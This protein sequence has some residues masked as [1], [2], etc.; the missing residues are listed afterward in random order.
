MR[1][2]KA[3]LRFALATFMAFVG[4]LIASLAITENIPN[5]SRLI[6]VSL[7]AASFGVFG[8]IL[9]EALS[10]LFKIWF[11]KFRVQLRKLIISNYS[12]IASLAAGQL[13]FARRRK[14]KL[15]SKYINPVLVDT[16]VLVDGRVG[17]IVKSGFI[18]RTMFI[19]PSVISELHQLSDSKDDLKRIRGRR[20]LDV[21]EAIRTGKNA[22][23]EVLEWEPEK[24]KVD[25][26]LIEASRKL[27]AGLMTVDFNLG[28]VARVR[29]IKVMNINELANAVKTVILPSE[30]MTI[31]ISV[32]GKGK[33][34]G[35]GFLD[36]GTMVVVEGGASFV[37]QELKVKVNKV[38]QTAAGKMI[39]ARKAY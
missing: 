33:D 15:A 35:V 25:D 39:F 6:I 5:T 26:K 32:A 31:S 9:P 18:D 23:V 34:Q 16:S 14:K 28:K 3:I 29:G 22:K 2:R 30:E 36:D 4:T 20:G 19:L 7:A 10:R 37:G 8:L 21:L 27:K 38:L 13:G 1:P 17:D 12:E 11:A 24:V